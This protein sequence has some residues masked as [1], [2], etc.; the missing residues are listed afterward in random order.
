[1]ALF[2]YTQRHPG[3]NTILPLITVN[4]QYIIAIVIVLYVCM[5]VKIWRR[6][7]TRV[8]V[9]TGP[10]RHTRDSLRVIP[11][12]LYMYINVQCLPV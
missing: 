1:M 9:H 10:R 2:I 12:N 11:C 6:Q 5:Y 8:H 4:Y 3:L 7:H